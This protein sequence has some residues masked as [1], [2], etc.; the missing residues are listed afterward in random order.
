M[1]LG[2][3]SDSHDDLTNINRAIDIFLEKNVE[4]IIH[5]GDIISPPII[6]EF[7]RVTDKGIRFCGILGNND[8]EK[9]GLKEMFNFINGEFLGEEGKIDVDGLKIGIYHGHEIKKKNKMINSGKFDVFIYGHSHN[10]DPKDEKL[11]IVGKTIIFNPG[12][13]HSPAQSMV[14]ERNY[15]RE[16]SILIFNTKNKDFNFIDLK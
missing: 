12:S 11:N 10:R 9:N 7:K 1:I 4:L 8:G 14:G 6:Q 5:A 3:I 16:P 13:S 2:I 15:F